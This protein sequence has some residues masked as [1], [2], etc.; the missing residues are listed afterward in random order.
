MLNGYSGHY[1]PGQV[2]FEVA[3]G[4]FPDE[5]AINLLR[6]RGATHVTVTCALYG[7]GCDELVAAADA[8]PAFRIVASGRWQGAPVRLYEIKR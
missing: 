7:G 8:V 1:P 3:V 4:S 6:G 2:D 5:H